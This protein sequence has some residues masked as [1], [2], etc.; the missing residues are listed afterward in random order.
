MPCCSAHAPP[1]L[2]PKATRRLAAV[3]LVSKP[4]ASAPAACHTPC[5]GDSPVERSPGPNSRRRASV[6]S[7]MSDRAMWTDAP[8]CCSSV[9]STSV[10]RASAPER[11]VRSSA[12]APR[13]ASQRAVAIPSPPV[14][15]VIMWPA[16]TRPAPAAAAGAAARSSRGTRT[17]AGASCSETSGSLAPPN[18]RTRASNSGSAVGVY[19]G[20]VV[21]LRSAS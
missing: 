17:P 5:S 18:L 15:P 20:P 12:P 11:D 19:P 8:A 2:A 4:S 3:W 6:A 21:A 10:P 13:T 7:E 16:S 9:H 14:P 1:A